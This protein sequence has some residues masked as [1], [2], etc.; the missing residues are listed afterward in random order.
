M[1]QFEMKQSAYQS[2]LKNRALQVLLYLIDR[3]NKEQTCFPAV[4]TISRDLH[5]SISTV[6]RAMRELVEAGYVE[7][8]SRFR[9]GN[10]GQTSNL[11]TLH[12][13]E[14]GNVSELTVEPE[15]NMQTEKP[16]QTGEEPVVIAQEN[17]DILCGEQFAG[18]LENASVAEQREKGNTDVVNRCSLLKWIKCHA[19]NN[20]V[21]K[22]MGIVIVTGNKVQ[23]HLSKGKNNGMKGIFL[24]DRQHIIF[25]CRWPGEGVSLIPP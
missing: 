23:G 15:I 2:Q 22:T 3:S 24:R 12:F 7:K 8:E 21:G 14:K 10:R 5:I 4:P 9:E 19:D 20:N 1:N 25:T 16:E 18:R 11:Y 6:K 13:T 17:A